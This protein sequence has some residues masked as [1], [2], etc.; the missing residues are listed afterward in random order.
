MKHARSLITIIIFVIL[1]ALG[2]L[3][4]QTKSHAQVFDTCNVRFLKEALPDDGTLFDFTCT[5]EGGEFCGIFEVPNNSGVD[6]SFLVEE[7]GVTFAETVPD[8]WQLDDIVCEIT[9]GNPNNLILQINEEEAS[10]F[11]DCLE[12]NTSAICTFINSRTPRNIPTLS[13]WGVV[14][15]A[16]ILGIVGLMVM[17]RR[18][19]TA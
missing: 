5:F 15:M 14:A 3:V 8:G 18:N 9:G 2:S 16:G 13:E 1:V 4:L 10:V 7:V 6:F 17:R 11:T 12:P 19:L